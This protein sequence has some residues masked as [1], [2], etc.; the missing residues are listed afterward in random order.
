MIIDAA[1]ASTPLPD[2]CFARVT[3][4]VHSALA[5]VGLTA[6]VADVLAARAI[7]ANVVAG[8]YHDHIFV[9]YKQ[10]FDALDALQSLAV[11]KM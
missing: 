2:E 6:A 4:S 11:T 9:P 10:R 5:A 3:L 1:V 7:P 8:Y